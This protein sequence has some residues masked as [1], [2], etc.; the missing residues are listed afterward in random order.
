[1]DFIPTA[2]E[3]DE[4][5]RTHNRERIERWLGQFTAYRT[6]LNEEHLKL[7]RAASEASA[8]L[9]INTAAL[10]NCDEQIMTLKKLLPG[11]Y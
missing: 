2:E 10:K 3:L 9:K 1:M 8:D 11:R 5:I 4:A 7:I 6:Q